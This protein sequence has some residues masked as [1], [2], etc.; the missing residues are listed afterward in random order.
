MK[1][2]VEDSVELDDSTDFDDFLNVDDSLDFNDSADSDVS[3]DVSRVFAAINYFFSSR[4][5]LYRM[6][7]V[8]IINVT[9]GECISS[10]KT[11]ICHE[12]TEGVFVLRNRQNQ[13]LVC[14]IKTLISNQYWEEEE[15]TVSLRNN[16][17]LE[18]I[19]QRRT[20]RYENELLLTPGFI[21]SA[22]EELIVTWHTFD[23]CYGVHILDAKTGETCNTMLEE[24]KDIIDCKFAGNCDTLVCCS[25]DNL[26]RL[27]N[28]KTGHL[29]SVLDIEER[30]CCL[31]ACL[32]KPLVAIG[33][34]GARLKF[35]HVE[36]PKVKETEEKKG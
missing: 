32:D 36:L 27:L 9:S 24:H 5:E 22:E 10:V 13:L 18:C 35:I 16:S 3:K 23:L 17:V 20:E 2:I 30:P 26:L 11:R 14:T 6:L 4:F 19:W 15:L 1:L 21:L 25:E 33:L 12:K 29:L 28:V 34:S 8:D 7:D 31:G